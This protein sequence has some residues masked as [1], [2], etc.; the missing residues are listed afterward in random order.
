MS[1]ERVHVDTKQR[2]YD[3][4]IGRALLAM[5]GEKLRE[6]L[7]G[8]TSAIVVCD[9]TV[10]RLFSAAVMESLS[11]AGIPAHVHSFPHGEEHKT[12]RTVMGI[13]ESMEDH[14]LQRSSAVVALGGGVTGDMAGLAAALY[15]RGIPFIQLPT[16]L[17]AAQD[18]SVGGKTAVD[19]RAKNMVGAF[20]QPSLVLC[21]CDALEK[22]PDSVFNDGCAEMIKHGAIADPGLF[23]ML[24]RGEHRTSLPECIRR[25]VSV[26]A[27]VVSGDELD[28][29]ARQILN[30]GHT[31]GH[32]IEKRSD[33]G[34]THGRAVAAGMCIM[35]RACE[36]QGIAAP[37]SAARLEALV[38][39]CS[40]PDGTALGADELYDAALSDKKRSGD[41]ISLIRMRSIGD[42]YISREPTSVLREVL[43]KG[44]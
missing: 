29:G 1:M 16:T 24:E 22:L 14:S 30:F 13:L 37:G 34:E 5:T 23:A 9:D 44:L 26:K 8:C 42:C 2:S 4:L 32:A 11:R 6:V 31:I 40:L 33:F 10:E 41:S 7:P 15:M 36:K 19:L 25:S 20:W 39:S 28:T 18:S 43:E 35:A 17:L 21:D 3:I 27:K 38:R 12:M